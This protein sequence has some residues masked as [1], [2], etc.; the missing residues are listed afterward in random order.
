VFTVVSFAFA[1]ILIAAPVPDDQ[2]PREASPSEAAP[3]NPGESSP[4]G[5]LNIPLTDAPSTRTR[6][7]VMAISAAGVPEEYAVGLTESIATHA[8]Q[9]GVFDTIS[10]KQISS[11]LAYEK[12]KELLGAC[13][14]D[15]CYLQI[16]QTVKADHLL[17]GNVAKV[18]D[19]LVLN[20]VLIDSAQGKALKRTSRET[21]SAS[22]LMSEASKASTIVL[23]P[24]LTSRR[25][26]LKVS[27]NVGDAS[28]IVDD[29]RRAEGVG[30]VIPLAAGPHVLKISKDGFYSTTADVF[31]RPSRVTDEV[32]KLIPAKDTIEAYETKASIMRY[33]G[34][35]TGALAIAGAV[36]AGIFYA[37]ATE[38]KAFVDRYA[39]ALDAQRA[40]GS[41]GTY[42]QARSAEDSFNANQTLYIVGLGTAVAAGA[43]SLYLLIAG[44]DP[45]RYEEFH[46]L[47]Q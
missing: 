18:G 35:A 38:D 33:G 4:S 20:L 8:A 39:S 9:T 29:E 34:Y 36:A 14:Q 1:S 47:Q 19:K 31:V 42:D 45:D 11:L 21:T 17:A 27:A 30:Q 41:V 43:A 16:A 6:L 5:D 15:D 22:A 7:A 26:F 40:S 37:N 28:V 12:R 24:V 44:D 23:Q 46:S 3:S 2:A 25:G 32:V 13:T 10:P